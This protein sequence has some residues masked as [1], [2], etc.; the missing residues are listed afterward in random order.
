MTAAKGL[1]EEEISLVVAV[2]KTL[3]ILAK[4]LEDRNPAEVIKDLD[5]IS[6]LGD[7]FTGGIINKTDFLQRIKDFNPDSDRADNDLA[8]LADDL[9]TEIKKEDPE[10]EVKDQEL[11]EI[12]KKLARAIQA[13]ITPSLPKLNP[14]E[15]GAIVGHL[16]PSIFTI[17]TTRKE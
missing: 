1:S 4:V 10:R 8:V 7:K 9:T 14:K 6:L 17:L 16:G 2:K 11:K 3:K 13:N 15:E 5:P 12:I